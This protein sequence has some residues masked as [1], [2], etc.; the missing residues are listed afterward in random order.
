MFSTATIIG[1]DTLLTAAHCLVNDE[2]NGQKPL[3]IEFLPSYCVDD[4][5]TYR[6]DASYFTDEWEALAKN[7]KAGGN[8]IDY[9]IIKFKH[10][11]FKKWLDYDR[12]IKDDKNK[13]T[14]EEEVHLAGYPSFDIDRILYLSPPAIVDGVNGDNT[15]HYQLKT[16]EGLSGALV[17]VQRQNK[18]FGGAIHTGATHN[19]NLSQG[20]MLINKPHI[21]M[22]RWDYLYNIRK[23]YGKK[24]KDSEEIDLSEFN[25]LEIS[26]KRDTLSGLF[27][28]PNIKGIKSSNEISFTSLW[29]IIS[30]TPCER[31][32]ID[33]I[34]NVETLKEISCLKNIKSLTF[35][36]KDSN[37]IMALGLLS[38]LTSLKLKSE[39]FLKEHVN[40][41]QKLR[42]LKDLSLE[43]NNL[44]NKTQ[45]DLFID[46]RDRGLKPILI[47]NSTGGSL[48]FN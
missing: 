33:L 13:P 8:E 27:Q 30:N 38:S 40:I 34:S 29:D 41:F 3:F 47:K 4:S 36:T 7:R 20:F 21:N 26:A 6:A 45:M 18:L 37:V 28:F 17:T 46:L 12:W 22:R 15:L 42:N 43:A 44:D 1:P 9:A 14:T 10:T 5:D 23:N 32:S 31:L 24:I 39:K 11:I 35:E 19:N 2:V 25:E 48:L 16:T